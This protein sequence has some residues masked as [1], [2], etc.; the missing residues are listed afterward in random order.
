MTKDF[1][2]HVLKVELWSNK[3]MRLMF[4]EE[5]AHDADLMVRNESS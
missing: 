3:P 2:Y 5:S 4:I 1:I